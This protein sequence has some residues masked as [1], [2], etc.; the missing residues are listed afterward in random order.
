MVVLGE[1][2]RRKEWG[3]FVEVG[4]EVGD[5]LPSGADVVH[6]FLQQLTAF[7]TA[8]VFLQLILRFH[9]D[10]FEDFIQAGPFLTSFLHPCFSK[11]VWLPISSISFS[12]QS[13]GEP[14]MA[15][16]AWAYVVFALHNEHVEVGVQFVHRHE[17][18]HVFQI[19]GQFP[20][21][22]ELVLLGVFAGDVKVVE[23]LDK[24]AFYVSK[25]FPDVALSGVDLVVEEPR[26]ILGLEL[27]NDV[28]N[29]VLF[30]GKK[31]TLRL[32]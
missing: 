17:K 7:R 30:G 4:D 15:V 3:V 5:G 14:T 9:Y 21:V 13:S 8:R 24:H 6:G 16:G 22:D 23:S 28:Q 32:H 10:A 1:D 11:E 12:R 25:G 31:L 26:A 2:L 20:H 27:D 18:F 29:I 19:Y